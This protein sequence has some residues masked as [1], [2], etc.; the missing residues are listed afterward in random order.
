MAVCFDYGKLQMGLVITLLNLAF[1]SL[2]VHKEIFPICWKRPLD[3][4]EICPSTVRIDQD[5]SNWW[6]NFLLY[7]SICMYFCLSDLPWVSFRKESAEISI[8]FCSFVF[9]FCITYHFLFF[10]SLKNPNLNFFSKNPQSF[11]F[12]YPFWIFSGFLLGLMNCCSGSVWVCRECCKSECDIWI[13]CCWIEFCCCKTFEG[14][15]SCCQLKCFNH[16]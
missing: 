12:S 15:V 13:V 6:L 4:S 14:S 11:V 3:R 7:Q 1:W 9:F 16:M 10:R 2:L 8:L 5:R